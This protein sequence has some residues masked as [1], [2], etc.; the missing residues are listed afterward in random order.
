MHEILVQRAWGKCGG[1]IGMMGGMEMQRFVEES[2][3]N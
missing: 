2:S 3:I 1:V